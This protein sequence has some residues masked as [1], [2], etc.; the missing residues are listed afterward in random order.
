MLTQ[1]RKAKEHRFRLGGARADFVASLGKKLAKARQFLEAYE[2]SPENTD[3]LEALRGQLKLIDAGAKMVRLAQVE[4]A[5]AGG[6]ALLA[7]IEANGGLGADDSI[8]L[9]HMLEDLPALAWGETPRRGEQTQEPP[10]A[11]ETEVAIAAA[12]AGVQPESTVTPPE[13][14]TVLVVGAA[15]L[16]EAL[17]ERDA[18]GLVFGCEHTND[19]QAAVDIARGTAPDLIVLEA[20]VDY[21]T[22]L[23]EALMD[24][25]LTE[26]LPVVVIGAFEAPGS[27]E[28]FVA[29]GVA[30]TLKKPIAPARFRSACEETIFKHHGKAMRLGLGDPTLEQLGERLADEVR[31]AIVDA[32]DEALRQE[33]VPMGQGTEVFGAIWGAIARVR[34]VVTAKT[35]GLVR[36]SGSGPEGATLLAPSLELSEAPPPVRGVQTRRGPSQEVRLSGRTILVCDD[37]PGVTWFLADL[38]KGAGCNV[39]EALNGDEALRLACKTTP[40]VI[41][42]DILMPGIDGFALCRAIKRDVVLRDVPV[43]L[44]SWKEDLLQR[45][46]ELGAG[47]TAYLRKESDARAILA[48]VRET[49]RPRTRVEARLKASGEVRGRLDGLTVRSLLD[50]VCKTRTSARISVRDASFLYEIEIRN[51][52]PVRATRTAGDGSL[53]SG[54]GV[55]SALLGVGAGRFLVSASHGIINGDLVGDLREQLAR[56]VGVARAA[57]RLLGSAHLLGI[58]RIVFDEAGIADYSRATPERARR[59]LERLG[60]GVSPR[61]LL[62]DAA[63]DAY[64]MEELL[65]DVAARGLVRVIETQGVDL[66]GPAIENSLRLVDSRAR[67][68]I[69]DTPLPRGKTGMTPAPIVGDPVVLISDNPPAPESSP[70]VFTSAQETTNVGDVDYPDDHPLL[71]ASATAFSMPIATISPHLEVSEAELDARTLD[72]TDAEAAY[73]DSLPDP[74]GALPRVVTI[75]VDDEEEVEPL[76]DGRKSHLSV[77]TSTVASAAAAEA[78]VRLRD[79]IDPMPIDA[80]RWPMFVSLVFVLAFAMGL[81][82]LVRP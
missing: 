21:A 76:E 1:E 27:Q 32:V 48:R 81:F 6:L 29:L 5:I 61:E 71:A 68:L 10:V 82:Y 78:A 38:L 36:F 49:L 18:D 47:A 14:H 75:D 37:D 52:A 35:D 28:G 57:M 60:A 30:K 63:C 22:E 80:R 64:L 39:I 53:L 45:V 58:D 4:S 2:A 17:R 12:I 16:A 15:N 55:F 59:I 79:E 56:P 62:A 33:R 31:L 43:I 65:A 54:P 50:I 40:D 72:L 44:L 69:G 9:A 24:D 34:E 26:P 42:S 13:V 7:R 74:T 77:K 11:T 19:A 51:S 70:D 66:L 73:F 23:V 8:L 41:I 20:E 3:A 25:P 46:R 67:G